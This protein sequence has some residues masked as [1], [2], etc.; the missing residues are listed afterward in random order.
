MNC[1]MCKGKLVDGFI[2]YP[3]DHG[4]Q[5]FLIKEVP[6]KICAQCSE[7]F[8]DDAVFVKIEEII[9]DAKKTNVEFEILKF[10]A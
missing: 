4:A 2:N 3:V 7:S 6:A 8:I 9:K 10:A 1:V 5:F